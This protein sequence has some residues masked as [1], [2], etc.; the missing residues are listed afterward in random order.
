MVRVYVYRLDYDPRIYNAV[1]NPTLP[2]KF[3][4]AASAPTEPPTIAGL[5]NK[6]Y[7]AMDIVPGKYH[8]D[9]RMMRGRLDLD[10]AANKTLFLRV[11]VGVECPSDETDT[12]ET[13]PTSI[14]VMDAAAAQAELLGMK[15]V[16]SGNVNDKK[17]VIIPSK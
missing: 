17:L 9:T 6:R 12:C 16:R 4:V 13:R 10:V 11:D 3:A 5:K 1:F 2:I 7:F 15:S 14:V 8:F